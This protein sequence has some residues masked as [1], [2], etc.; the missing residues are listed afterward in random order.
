MNKILSIALISAIT[1]VL[2]TGCSSKGGAEPGTH[3]AKVSE[4]ALYVKTHNNKKI[5]EA[6]EKA[7]EKTGWKI[8]E[9]K[10]NEVIA[11][12][13]ENEVTVSSS[14]KFSEGYV[15]FSND[16]AASDLSDAIMEELNKDKATH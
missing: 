12:K 13:T 9:F 10:M 16:S 2:S 3:N 11:E 7:G 6:I 1:L 14:I 5:A 4:K 8:T 15:E